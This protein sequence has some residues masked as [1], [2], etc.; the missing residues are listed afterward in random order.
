MKGKQSLQRLPVD[1]LV[2]H[3]RNRALNQ[4]RV[5]EMANSIQ[6]VGILAPLIVTEHLTEY[7]RW[8]LLDGHHRAAAAKQ[9]GLDQVMCIIRHGLDEDT[10][11]QLLIMLI[12]NC[13]RQEMSALDRAE[14]FGVLRR[15][16]L[17]LEQIAKRSGF[18]A[19]WVSESLSLLELDG[20]T[21]DRVRAGEVGVGQ[22]KAAIRQVRAAQRDSRVSTATAARTA[23]PQVTVEAAH[24]TRKHPL[25]GQAAA[26]CDHTDTTTGRVR[27]TVGGLACGQCWEQ[28]IRS[29]AAGAG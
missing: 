9:L 1:R 12:G 5:D 24:F 14:L 28:V 2:A 15:G 6:Q 22:A 26:L 27:P 21:Q 10:D 23:K 20:E 17:T 8:L 18:S 11:E 3:D 19:G 25:S 16:G 13:Q 29:D 7:N 4:D